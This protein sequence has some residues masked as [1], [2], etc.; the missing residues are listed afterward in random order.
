METTLHL[1]RHGSIEGC[2]IRRFRGQADVPL[3]DAGRRQA[4]WWRE[5][6]GTGRFTA[7]YA[8]DLSRTME[9]ARI[10]TGGDTPI[11]AEPRLREISLGTWEGR[12][13]Q[14]VMREEPEAYAAR[15]RDITRYRT[16]G[17]E[18][19]EDLQNRTWPAFE[20]IARAAGGEILIVCHGGVIRTLLCRILGMPLENL[21]RIILDYAGLNIIVRKENGLALAAMNLTPPRA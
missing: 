12:T 15:G 7:V 11:I 21:F 4:A 18:S 19:F 1:M 2:E 8:S 6:L 3:D 13:P 17:G 5:R 14:E 10:V 16:P 9:T 20:D